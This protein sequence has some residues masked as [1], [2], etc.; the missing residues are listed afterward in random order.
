MIKNT[1]N[2][3]FKNKVLNYYMNYEFMISLHSI[4][5]P[6]FNYI[7]LLDN[8]LLSNIFKYY[9]INKIDIIYILSEDILKNI[10]KN[11]INKIMET[12]YKN[13]DC[14]LIMTTCDIDNLD[15]TKL[16]DFEYFLYSKSL[17][18]YKN[19]YKRII[20]FK[21]IFEDKYMDA[22]K[23]KN[24]HLGK[25]GNKNNTKSYCT[26]KEFIENN[27]FLKKQIK[28]YYSKITK[29][30]YKIND[31]D[32]YSC[33]IINKSYYLIIKYLDIL[34]YQIKLLETKPYMI[35]YYNDVLMKINTK[36]FEFYN[37]CMCINHQN[38]ILNIRINN[39]KNINRNIIK[40]YP[41]QKRNNV[42][43]L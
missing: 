40:Y 29:N 26:I 33:F 42:C 7:P 13:K 27:K 14:E 3:L 30:K 36:L 38:T 37:N 35:R 1:K 39:Y 24:A 32:I 20:E 28:N 4:Y 25:N 18:N 17:I 2:I 41:T 5:N 15:K 12:I 8:E 22:S 34:N 16:S 21:E 23:L 10:N 9:E 43:F 31:D 6:Y 11:E 19:E